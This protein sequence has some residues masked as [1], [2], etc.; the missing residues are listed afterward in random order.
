MHR[1]T[2]C[3]M[4]DVRAPSVFIARGQ[5]KPS[6]SFNLCGVRVKVRVMR[7]GLVEWEGGGVLASKRAMIDV[8]APTPCFFARGYA[9]CPIHFFFFFPTQNTKSNIIIICRWNLGCGSCSARSALSEAWLSTRTRRALACTSAA[10]CLG[11][12]SFPP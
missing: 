9:S 8:R 7:L 3:A 6:R 2:P 1:S 4:I 12:T 10:A 11:C 5:K